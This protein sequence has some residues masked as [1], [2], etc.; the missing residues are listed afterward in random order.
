MILLQ[1]VAAAL[2]ANAMVIMWF[3][4]QSHAAECLPLSSAQASQRQAVLQA[5]YW[6]AT[7]A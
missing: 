6:T 3:G 1:R 2:L 4:K 5:G 7:T